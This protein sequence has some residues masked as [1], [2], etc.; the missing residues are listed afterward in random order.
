MTGRL[1]YVANARLPTEKAHGHAIVKMCEAYAKAGI[2][3]ELWHPRRRQD[4]RISGRRVFDYYGVAP[5]FGVRTL[6]N[7][8]VIAIESRF[9]P[10]LFPWVMGAHDLA[11]AATVAARA[12]TR[13]PSTLCHTRDPAV[14]WCLTAARIPTILEV[15]DPPAG[16]RR[17]LVR[18]VARRSDLRGVVALTHATQDALVAEGVDPRRILVLGSGVDLAGFEDLPSPSAC[19]AAHELPPDRVVV[20]YVGRFQALGA[21]KGLLTAVRAVGSIRR[22]RGDAPLLLCVGGPMDHVDEYIAAGVAEGGRASDFRFVDHVPSSEVP[23]WIRACDVGLIPSP[24][25][26]H[27]TKYS[28]PMKLFEFMAAG[29]PVVASDLQAL[30]E[31][32]VHDRNGWLVSADSPGDLADGLEVLVHDAGLRNRLAARAR[33]DVDAHTWSRRAEA[34]LTR[35]G[36]EW[37]LQRSEP[38]G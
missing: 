38:S 15:H 18:Q 17:A 21:E 6:A 2:E 31:T 23:G 7:I 29:V 36:D 19:R 26:D 22:T 16:P 20:G 4:P 35:F 25:S 37:T 10:S 5:T 9:P 14:A 27:F 3:V 11:W 12:A 8:D 24:R 13:R 34:I 32:I 28:S 30:R 1:L 33:T